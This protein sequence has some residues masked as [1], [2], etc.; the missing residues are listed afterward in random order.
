MRLLHVT[1]QYRPA[2]GG[3]E[4]YIVNL[5]E[6]LAR[7]GHRVTVFT[8]RSLDYR[9]WRNEL[10][11]SES[12][13]G[14]SV[15]R[16][17]GF[18]RGARTWRMLDYGYRHY[19]RTRSRLYEPLIFLGNG[20]VCPGLFW[21]LLRQA[22]NYDVVHI[23]NLH[24]AHAATAYA[25][26]R[27]RRLPVVIT[28]HI[29]TEQP[30]TYD[31]HYMRTILRGSDHVIADTPAERQ[32]LIDEGFDPQR[33][34][35]A[36]VGLQLKQFPMQDAQSCRRELA[37]PS[38]A[39]ALLFLGRKTE[40]K[41]LD[42]VLQAFAA[43]QQLYP[44]LYLLAVGPET[45]HSHELWAQYQELPNLLHLGKVPD[46]TR[47][48]ALNACDCLIVPSAGEAFG[49]VFLEAWAVG[50]PVIGARTRAVESLVT[51]GQDGYLVPPGSVPQ[52]L[53]R[54]VC[55]LENP[56]LGQQMGRH[57]QVKLQN[58]YTVARITDIIEG[59]YLRTLRR[60]ASRF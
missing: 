33:V 36:G 11:T 55:L 34:T 4:Q 40:Y 44:Q 32:Y 43:L 5:S 17:S 9:S 25:A 45:D 20:P 12:L 28:P 1:H 57:G 35:T 8:S 3:A 16:F 54:I 47:L 51:D 22:D 2:V 23:N 15:H 6:E 52:L 19:W 21:T 59:V 31:T 13:D 18:A 56:S 39:F 26:A 50:K 42:L 7:R 38:Q 60:R 41:G 24:Y 46:E 37:I 49:I 58:R 27:W 14:V 48:A 29:H 30:V 53:E 10:P